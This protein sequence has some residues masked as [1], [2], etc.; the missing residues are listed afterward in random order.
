VAE[1][2]LF[3]P[4]RLYRWFDSSRSWRPRSASLS[5][6]ANAMNQPVA[7]VLKL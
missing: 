4:E 5:V 1:V 6:D 2:S 3:A 7:L